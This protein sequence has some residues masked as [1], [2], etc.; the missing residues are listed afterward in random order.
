MP[1]PTPEPPR[2]P[3][4]VRRAAAGAWHVPAGFGILLRNP[5]LWPLAVLPV[6]LAA[7]FV[8]LGAVLGIFLI[9]R[10]ETQFALTRLASARYGVSTVSALSSPDRSAATTAAGS[11][12]ARFCR[13]Q[14]GRPISLSRA[15]SS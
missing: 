6:A 1:E 12:A 15:L 2:R 9:P 5:R 10:V 14:W 13:V 8:F 7:L 3:G 11:S 4:F